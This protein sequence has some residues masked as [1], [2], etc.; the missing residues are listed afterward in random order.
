MEYIN[1]IIHGDC[2]QVMKDIPDKS[3]DMILCDLPYGTTACSWDTVIP[4]EPLWEQYKRIVKDNACICLFGIEPFS[5]YLRLSNIKQYRYDWIWHKNKSGNIFQY[6]MKPMARHEIISIFTKYPIS[7]QYE[8]NIKYN[9]DLKKCE[10]ISK[11]FKPKN[12]DR[13]IDIRP[14]HKN[15]SKLYIREYEGY[16]ESIIKIDNEQ[17]KY[18]P[19]QKPVKLFEYLIKTYTDENDIVLD[20][21]AG[22][23]TT[24]VACYETNRKYICIEKEKKYIDIIHKRLKEKQDCYSL[25][26]NI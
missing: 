18:H 21:C 6:K 26:E 2:I 5:S 12:N 13:S 24:A 14:C 20:N 25:L 3:I 16:P 23:G 10:K 11:E 1:Q 7:Y 22:S 8:N 9:P 15:K 4:F 19:T 17:N